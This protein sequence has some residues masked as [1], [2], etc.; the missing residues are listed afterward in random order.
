MPRIVK[1]IPM[2]DL[3]AY[4][5]ESMDSPTHVGSLQI[6]KPASGSSAEIVQRILDEYRSCEVAPPF[7]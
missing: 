7:N 6:F 4:L 1:N 3:M 5:I 2:M